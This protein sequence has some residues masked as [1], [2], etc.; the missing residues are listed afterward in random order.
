MAR[1]VNRACCALFATI[2]AVFVVKV[3]ARYAFGASLAWTDEVVVI[4]FIWIIFLG[5][6]FVLA[7]DQQIRFDL[8]IRHA[9]PRTQRVMEIARNAAIALIFGAA[10]PTVIDYTR[11]LWRER[12]PVLRWRLDMIYACFAVFMAAIILRAAWRVIRPRA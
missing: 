10:L 1:A 2:F 9:G 7:E 11:F 4:L 5:N 6:G 12:T 8:L 3:A